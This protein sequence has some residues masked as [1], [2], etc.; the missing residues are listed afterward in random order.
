VQPAPTVGWKLIYVT[1]VTSV[2]QNYMNASQTHELAVNYA[3][4]I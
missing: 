2:E 4:S 1:G 3:G